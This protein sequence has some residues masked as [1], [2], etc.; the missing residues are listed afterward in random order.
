MSVPNTSE[1][2]DDQ[3]EALIRKLSAIKGSAPELI[4]ALEAEA[5]SR[6]AKQSNRSGGR[7]G[8]DRGRD[9]RRSRSHSYEDEEP[10]DD[11]DDDYDEGEEEE[12]D[13]DE[14]TDSED[15]DEFDEDGPCVGYGYSDEV[16]VISEMTTPTVVSNLHVPAEERYE[17]IHGAKKSNKPD[18]LSQVNRVNAAKGRG[19]NS[20]SSRGS[21]NAGLNSDKRKTYTSGLGKISETAEAAAVTKPPKSAAATGTRGTGGKN[22]Q[23]VRQKSGDGAGRKASSSRGLRRDNSPSRG[24]KK[25]VGGKR[26]N[27]SSGSG[28]GKGSN[29]TATTASNDAFSDDW[30]KSLTAADGATDDSGFPFSFG[31]SENAFVSSSNSFFNK[32]AKGGGDTTD[33]FDPFGGGDPFAT[34]AARP[35]SKKGGNDGFGDSDA[36]G[37]STGSGGRAPKPNST[38]SRPRRSSGME[39]GSK[40]RSSSN[41]DQS[42]R[43]KKG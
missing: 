42:P 34:Q 38:K 16:S 23:P 21:S 41:R 22:K 6:L 39:K 33:P 40:S 13:D 10:D 35:T 3:I 17:E 24:K 31:D 11:Y 36:F 30:H 26:S 4:A 1:L 28:S 27:H 19:N 25:P 2:D 12:E 43:R 9:N 15:E 18:L 8:R 20:Q 37:A 14:E 5:N 32:N 7:G 29:K